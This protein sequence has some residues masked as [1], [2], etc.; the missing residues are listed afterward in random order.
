MIALFAYKSIFIKL[1]LA[2]ARTIPTR[3][4]ENTIAKAKTLIEAL[5]RL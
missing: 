5:S 3:R 1:N 4:I 2:K